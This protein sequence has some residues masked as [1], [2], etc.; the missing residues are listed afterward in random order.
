[1]LSSQNQLATPTAPNR[2][3][4]QRPTSAAQWTWADTAADGNVRY[5][6]TVDVTGQVPVEHHPAAVC[7]M[8]CLYIVS[9]LNDESIMEAY[10]LLNDVYSWQ[11]EKL[12]VEVHE[13]QP[14]YLGTY[15]DD[16]RLER[17]PFLHKN[18]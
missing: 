18:W 9:R 17:T 15:R 12:K 10:E 11:Q 6:A 5:T 3:P 2:L 13:P 1:M 14:E 7:R 4:A 8:L 16:R